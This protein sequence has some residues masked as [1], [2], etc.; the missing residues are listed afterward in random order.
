MRSLS[1]TPDA[2]RDILDIWLFIH[3]DS[4]RHAD[5]LVEHIHAQCEK[6]RE[7]PH[8]DRVR[9]EFKRRVRSTPV[10]DYVIFYAVSATK[11]SVVRV[12]HGSRDLPAL[13]ES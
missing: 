8:A 7:F 11:L 13:L 2:R 9:L 10:G 12:V 6:L 3:R 5:R 1:Y 4:P